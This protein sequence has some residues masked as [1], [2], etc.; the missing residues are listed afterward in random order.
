[1]SEQGAANMNSVTKP[2]RYAWYVAGMLFVIYLFNYI[3]R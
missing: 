2:G 1:M 3:D